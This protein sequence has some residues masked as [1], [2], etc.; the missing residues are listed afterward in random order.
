[1]EHQLKPEHCITHSWRM[2]DLLVYD[3]A[4]VLHRKEPFK[5][6]RL[7]KSSRVFMDPERFAIPGHHGHG[8]S[9]EDAAARL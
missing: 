6:G 1:M 3:N 9:E 7:L 2:G 5:G 8:W 4:Q